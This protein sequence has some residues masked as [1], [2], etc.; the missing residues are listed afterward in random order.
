MADGFPIQVNIKNGCAVGSDKEVLGI[1]TNGN[2]SFEEF[3]NL[4]QGVSIFTLD[5]GKCLNIVVKPKENGTTVNLGTTINLN[6]LDRLLFDVQL[7][8]N[9][10]YTITKL[11]KGWKI[12]PIESIA[13]LE[14]DPQQKTNVTVGEGP[15]E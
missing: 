10:E 2:G 3:K 14:L 7:P 1:V 9:L 5:V 15:P 12:K 4:S 13:P 8:L 6:A 11:R